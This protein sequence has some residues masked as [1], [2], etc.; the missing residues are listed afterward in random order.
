MNRSQL[1]PS[2]LG[3]TMALNRC[4]G[5]LGK[6]LLRGSDEN[7]S[8]FGRMTMAESSAERRPQRSVFAL[9]ASVALRLLMWTKTQMGWGGGVHVSESRGVG[10]GANGVEIAGCG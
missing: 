10:T 9:G 7:P 4:A 8:Q 6:R 3:C 2:V 1:D 5:S